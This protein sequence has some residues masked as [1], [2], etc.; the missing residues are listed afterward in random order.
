MK[1]LACQPNPQQSSLLSG[2]EN[3]LYRKIREIVSKI[4][5]DMWVTTLSHFSKVNISESDY[6]I[7]H[8]TYKKDYNAHATV[9]E[10][11]RTRQVSTSSLISYGESL[12]KKSKEKLQF[13]T[14]GLFPRTNIILPEKK[15]GTKLLAVPVVIQGLE[16]HIV[17]F[18]VDFA[19]N[20]IEFYDS[21]GLTIQ[22]RGDAKLLAKNSN[23]EIVTLRMVAEEMK[24]K[25]GI[26]TVVQ[27]IEKHQYD[28][29][30][31]GVYV[32]NYLTERVNET[33][34][35]DIVGKNLAQINQ[36]RVEM[37]KALYPVS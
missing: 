36:F 1:I 16:D 21:K 33:K 10:L 8:E 25:Y 17:T 32:S 31:C 37:I 29:H 6:S 27:N 26:N 7:T 19:K 23:G 2:Q 12:E 14:G 24:T 28:C 35:E 13:V 30:N 3:A 15:E 18:V 11:K 4:L 22:D 5:C 34:M 9:A 20:R